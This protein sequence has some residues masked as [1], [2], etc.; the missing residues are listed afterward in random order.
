MPIE[1]SCLPPDSRRW[2]WSRR[3][4][5]RIWLG[6]RLRSPRSRAPPRLGD[7]VTFIQWVERPP[8]KNG[9]TLFHAEPRQQKTP[10]AP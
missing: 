8:G 6:L 7:I 4:I 10:D 5:N 3:N 1:P 2:G 9:F